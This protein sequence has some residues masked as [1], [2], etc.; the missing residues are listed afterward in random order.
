MDFD[1]IM[2]VG[3]VSWKHSVYKS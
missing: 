2:I 3:A 1:C